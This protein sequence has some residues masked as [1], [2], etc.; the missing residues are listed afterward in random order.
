MA[1]GKNFSRE[2]ELLQIGRAVRLAEQPEQ[3]RK[4]IGGYIIG[5]YKIAEDGS[6]S[7]PAFGHNAQNAAF[8]AKGLPSEPYCHACKHVM[9]LQMVNGVLVAEDILGGLTEPERE[10]VARGYQQQVQ[11]E[12]RR[13]VRFAEEANGKLQVVESRLKKQAVRVL[14]IGDKD[15]LSPDGRRARRWTFALG[16]L[17]PEE[18]LKVASKRFPAPDFQAELVLEN[19]DWVSQLAPIAG[20]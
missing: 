1:N 20:D 9:A 17:K 13:K 10:L 4:A 19:Q 12:A 14:C 5:G 15:F 11:I 7:C 8:D 16:G 3:F 2:R 18:A 6:C